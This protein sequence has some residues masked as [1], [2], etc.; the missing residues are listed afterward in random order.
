MVI[1]IKY[2]LEYG[3]MEVRYKYTE[4]NAYNNEISPTVQTGCQNKLWTFTQQANKPK[5]DSRVYYFN[6]LISAAV[7]KHVTGV[8]TSTL[9][10]ALVISWLN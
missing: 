3:F 9:L 10:E 2:T 8:H 1:Y 4:V 6:R 7:C 5:L